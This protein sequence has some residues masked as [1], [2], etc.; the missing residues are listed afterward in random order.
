LEDAD[1]YMPAADGVITICIC[2]KTLTFYE[3]LKD[4]FPMKG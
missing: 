1:I 3:R 4:K 2:N